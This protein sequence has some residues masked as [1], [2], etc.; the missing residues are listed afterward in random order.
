M[1]RSISFLDLPLL[2]RLKIYSYSGWLRPCP[3]ELVPVETQPVAPGSYPAEQPDCL[4]RQRKAGHERSRNS[5]QPDCICPKLP[6]QLLFVSRAIHADAFLVFHS[7]NKFVLRAHAANNLTRLRELNIRALSMINSLLIRLKCWPC[8]RGHEETQINSD[9]NSLNCINCR[10]PMVAGAPTLSSSDQTGQ[11]TIREW[12]TLC[13]YLSLAI[14]PGQLRFTLICDVAD[15][16]TGKQVIEPLLRL[17]TLKQCTIRLGRQR[18]YELTALARETSL[19]M[20]GSPILEPGKFPFGSLPKELR[21]YILGFTHLGQQGSYADRHSHLRIVRSKLRYQ[22][23]GSFWQACCRHCTETLIDCCCPSA[24]SAHSRGC[25]CRL[26]PFEVFLVNRPFRQDAMEVLF[27]QNCFEF[28]QGPEECIF[29]FSRLPKGALNYIRRLRFQ[30]SEDEVEHWDEWDCSGKWDR[31]VKFVKDNIELSVLS[32]V[33]TFKTRD[34]GLLRRH[35]KT[36]FIYDVYCQVTRTMR[37]LGGVYDICFELGWFIGLEPLMAKAVVGDK[38][39]HRHAE[40]NIPIRDRNR[41]K[42]KIPAWYKPSDLT[43]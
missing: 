12:D 41:R 17:P 36:R 8:L 29:F 24:R 23:I 30:V 14:S 31:L 11:D 38:Y 33:I 19:R 4:Y 9:D 16:D 35:E 39:R 32:I 28:V 43:G 34:L 13:R 5:S 18:K 25:D 3:I 15:L 42:F 37:I 22:R 1:S 27:T 21:L 6:T 10:T 2:V 40:T 20:M 7:Q 26:I